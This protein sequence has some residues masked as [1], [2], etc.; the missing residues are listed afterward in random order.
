M[1]LKKSVLFVA[2]ITAIYTGQISAKTVAKD[3]NVLERIEVFGHKISILN[4]DAAASISVLNEKEIARQQQAELTSLLKQLPGV[5][6]NGGVTPL[7]GQPA[8]R[9][10]YGE[11]IHISVDNVKRKSESDG[12]NNIAS[13]NSLGIDPGQ[14][15]QIQVLRGAD[16]LTVG[17]GAVGGSIRLVT[18]DAKDYLA[19]KNGFGARVDGLH[20][21]V[22]DSNKFGLSL[23]NLTDNLDTV[24]HAS[25]V[26]FSDIDVVAKSESDFDTPDDV[27]EV[28]LL[29][30]IKNESTRTNLTLKNT[31]YFAP[32]H[33]IQSK[34]DW[35]ET[36]SLDQPYG[37][38]QSL[39]IA[40]PTLAEDYSNDYIE[41]MVNY[42]YQPA[43]SLIDLDMQLVYSKKDYQKE[44]RGYIERRGNKMSFD[45]LSEGSTKRTS[46]RV[47][48]LSTFEGIIDHR[49]AIELN[50]EAENFIQSEFKDDKTSTY[51]G[52]SDSENLSFS[53]IDQAEFFDARILATGGFRYDTYKRSSNIFTS[54]NNNDDGELSNE[55]GLT[56]KATEYLNFYL[57][58]AEAFRAP[59]V[60]ELYKKDE[61]RCHIGG[62]IC[63]SEPQP[64]LKPETSTNYEAGFG[65]A[66]QDTSFA[67]QLSIKA[68]YFNNKIDNY[69]NNVPFM[70]Y[71]DSNGNKLQGSPGPNPANGVPVAT[72]R[73]YSAKNIG[74]LISTGIEV[75]MTYQL[76]K[77]DAYL[78]YSAM[79]MDVEGM[80]N[81]FLG[82]IDY[83]TQPYT[84]A[85]ADK[86]TLNL[87]YQ[88]F[89]S[90]NIGGQV[91][92]YAEQ[93]RL[94]QQYLDAGY[95]TDSY[96]VYNF[97]ASYYGDGSLSGVGIV[98]GIDNITDERYLRAPASEAN[99]PAELG[100]NY[101]VTV[102]YQF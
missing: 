99:D 84:E 13:I 79:K 21:S 91:L 40:Y 85:P 29:D 19:D 42:A 47:A 65:L 7:S 22:S 64:D 102:S 52:D 60:Q 30:K 41:A 3:Q 11:R 72:H 23:F 97:N 18:K 12:S 70:Y 45:K 87:N 69:I 81:F 92:A 9:G 55:L 57:K 36:K 31:W 32:T 48:N 43:S 16:S 8:I 39:A 25:Q 77:F 46:L 80:P 34:V 1:K 93:K 56:F 98:F 38:R 28:A 66:W 67:D 49:L 53:V 82:S 15:K 51:Y 94:P 37:Q 14:L 2:I 95:G 78:G 20:Q 6:I 58:Y 44:T 59:S 33:S 54:Y 17:S 24:F 83:Q 4:Q 90:F 75:E 73:D 35:S 74:L 27:E 88:L 5:D 50:Y 101:K 71:I 100:R 61:W 62:K 76:D 89:E 68:I 86:L 96:Q 26:K 10:L 63:Y